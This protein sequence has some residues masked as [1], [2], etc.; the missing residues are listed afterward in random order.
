M[1]NRIIYTPSKARI[2]FIRENKDK[3]YHWLFLPGGPGLGSEILK[4]LVALLN[5]PGTMC[6]LDL[7]GDG[8]NIGND[9]NFLNWQQALIEATTL[10]ENTLL[11]AHSSGGMFALSTP[12]IEKNIMG[13]VLMDSAPN[14]NWQK[15][16]AVWV[17]EKPLRDVAILQKQYDENPSNNTLKALTIACSPYFSTERNSEKI[18]ALLAQ[19]PFHYQSH[20]WAEKNF[21]STYEAK[22][23]P[24][25]I[26]TLVFSGD[27][28]YLTPLKLFSDA[29]LFRR[30]NIFIHTIKNAAHFPWIDNPKQVRQL[31]QEYL[32]KL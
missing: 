20:L 17:S 12:E 15:S 28:D 8:S 5:L 23:I 30:K 24:E 4:E 2:T 32:R 14:A 25:K 31:F 27:Q 21:D 18:K 3:N 11:V 29:V 16:F 13:L 6:L 9:K 7:P 10:F 19:L 26:P 1:T 22:W